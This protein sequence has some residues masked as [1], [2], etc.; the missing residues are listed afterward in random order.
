MLCTLSVLHSTCYKIYTGEHTTYL[1]NSIFIIQRELKNLSISRVI[2]ERYFVFFVVT[3]VLNFCMGVLR[4][5]K[6]FC[7]YSSNFTCIN[8]ASI[9]STV[10]HHK[11]YN[12]KMIQPDNL[13]MSLTVLVYAK[14]SLTILDNSGKCHPYHSL[15]LMM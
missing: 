2:Y 4:M 5:S 14:L 12:V 7:E 8:T 3:A 6:Y 11:S 1:L 10:T 9:L 13:P 15:V